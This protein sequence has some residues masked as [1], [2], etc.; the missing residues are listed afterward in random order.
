[1]RGRFLYRPI[2]RTCPTSLSMHPIRCF[3]QSDPH[4]A[5]NL[6]WGIPWRGNVPFIGE[7]YCIGGKSLFWGGWCPR[8][9]PDDLGE[10]PLDVANYLNTN[11]PLL[12]QQTGVNEKT[13]FIQGPLFTL[14]K[15]KA[16]AIGVIPNIGSVDDPPLAVQGQSPAS[17]LFSFDKYSSVAVL[18]DAVRDAANQPDSSR[19]LFVVPNAHVTHLVTSG[20]GVPSVQA[21]LDG[22][23]KTLNVGPKTAVILAMGTMES[24]RMALASFPTSPGNPGNELIGRNLMAHWRSNIFVRIKRSVFDP[25]AALPQAVQTGALMCEAPLRKVSSTCK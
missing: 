24:T 7:A 11:Y 12:E 6:V 10:W 4:A 9:L 17:G 19:R 5:R 21:A 22:T 15:N 8:L 18:I 3:P 2:C 14:L 25:A 20:G 23:L 16:A 13:D 1:M